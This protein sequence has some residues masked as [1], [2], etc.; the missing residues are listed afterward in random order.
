ML[1]KRLLLTALCTALALTSCAAP[2]GDD[3]LVP[4]PEDKPTVFPIAAASAEPVGTEADERF[5][6]AVSAFSEK[7]FSLCAADAKQKNLVLS[8]LSV[9][10]A[11]TLVSNGA[12]DST[13]AAFESLNGGIP[14]SEMNEYL[15]EFSKKLASTEESTVNT[16]NSV[17][18]N[19]AVF[20]LNEDFITA[21][22]K[23]YDALAKSV[24]FADKST[25]DEINR[26]VS[27][28]TDGMID[29][30]IEELPP[31]AAL[32][33]MNTV[34]F[35]GQW[36][37]PYEEYDI[38]DG[39]FTNLD[40][41]ET[42]VEYMRS[43]EHS[44]FEVENGVGFVKTYKDGYAFVGILPDESVGIEDF[45]ASLDLAE[46]SRAINS[47][48]EKVRVFLPKFEYESD[49]PLTDILSSMGLAEAF[50]ANAKLHGLG[51]G[52]GSPYI[53]SVLQKAK[54]I[55]DEKGTK[56][57]AMTEVMVMMTSVGPSAQ[58]KIIELNRPF[59]YMILDTE[60]M[61]PLF[62]GTVCEME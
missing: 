12:A 30:A 42:D 23:Y 38:S 10:Y 31:A 15:Y 6:D 34:L 11:L 57:A 3:A 29:K 13:L 16:A 41:S 40:G 51:T 32:V 33:L 28:H 44:Y 19:E 45:N 27:D 39:I 14:V 54:I 50:G 49:I 24:N 4:A 7:L 5:T 20:E 8:P 26:W 60:T 61:I 22:K 9:V 1:I 21:A 43:T 25:V 59:F 58:P 37:D 62:M 2:A 36:E 55:T 35:N 47:Q 48:G 52:S 53:S 56:A 17:W 46:I 18:T